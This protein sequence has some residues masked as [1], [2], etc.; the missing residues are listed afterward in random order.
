MN[1]LLTVIIPVFNADKHLRFCLQSVVDQ[2]YKNLDIL[3][4][5]DGST[6]RSR[7]IYSEFIQNDNR[8]RAIRVENGGVAQAR[9]VGIENALGEYIGFVDSDDAIHEKMYE[10]LIACMDDGIDISICGFERKTEITSSTT[11]DKISNTMLLQQYTRE[12]LLIKFLRNPSLIG[13]ANW[14]KLYRAS[15]A[16]KILFYNLKLGEDY[17]YNMM[18]ISRISKAVF[19]DLPTYYYRKTSGSLSN[20]TTFDWKRI[21]DQIMSRQLGYTVIENKEIKS[22]ALKYYLNAIL[23]GYLLSVKQIQ[24]AEYKSSYHKIRSYTE[25]S[26]IRFRD[27][28]KLSKKAIIQALLCMYLPYFVHVVYKFRR[29]I[30]NGGKSNDGIHFK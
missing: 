1:A 27:F 15:I 23:T 21:H 12:E 13:F 28:Y 29:S 30:T 25:S 3:V 10:I 7:E 9:N 20:L 6:D 18:Y 14:N 19:L 17:T 5:D 11:K 22:M 2:T 8:I 24:Y 26:G 4:I 16:K